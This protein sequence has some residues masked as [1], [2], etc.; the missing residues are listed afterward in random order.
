MHHHM[1]YVHMF[2]HGMAGREFQACIFAAERVGLRGEINE[3]KKALD[4]R[5]QILLLTLREQAAGLHSVH[6][7]KSRFNFCGE[8]HHHIHVVPKRTMNYFFLLTGFARQNE[9]SF[10]IILIIS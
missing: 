6:D 10:W 1:G 9:I 5:K 2:G 7:I 8:K 4:A 3:A